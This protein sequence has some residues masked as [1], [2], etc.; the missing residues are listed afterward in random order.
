MI[1]KDNILNCLKLRAIQSW[2]G[3]QT[4]P[5]PPQGGIGLSG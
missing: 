4:P 2:R 1:L 3:H 5:L